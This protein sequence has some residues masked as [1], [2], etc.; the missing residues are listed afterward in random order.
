MPLQLKLNDLAKVIVKIGS[1]A[2]MLLF[3]AL[4]IGFIIQFATDNTPR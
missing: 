1:I 4:F 3:V 2:G